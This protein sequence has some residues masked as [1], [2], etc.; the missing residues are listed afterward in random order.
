MKQRMAPIHKRRAKPPK[1]CLQNLTHS[2]VVFGGVKAFGPSRSK[3]SLALADVRPVFGFVQNLKKIF[4]ILK[5]ETLKP[6][7]FAFFS[8]R[9]ASASYLWYNSSKVIL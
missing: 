3:T 6:S 1:S 2:G 5:S 8:P 4:L 9:S 7:Y